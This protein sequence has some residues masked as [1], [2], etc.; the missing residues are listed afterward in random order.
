MSPGKR[1]RKTLWTGLHTVR[2][3]SLQLPVSDR[4]AVYTGQEAKYDVKKMG[5]WRPRLG[6]QLHDLLMKP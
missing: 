3:L 4:A 2:W 6:C 1:L 5:A